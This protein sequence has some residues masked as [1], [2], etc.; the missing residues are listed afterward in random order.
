MEKGFLVALLLA[1]FAAPA[2]TYADDHSD[3]LNSKSTADAVLYAS[4]EA[5]KACYS[6]SSLYEVVKSAKQRGVSIEQIGDTLSK[7]FRQKNNTLILQAYA[8]NEDGHTGSDNLF[9]KCIEEKK[10]EISKKL[11]S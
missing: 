5:S 10:V 4:F 2:L 3:Q 8:D 7:E 11:S 6:L 9:Y 1:S